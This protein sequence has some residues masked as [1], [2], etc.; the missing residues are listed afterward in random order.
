MRPR[1]L[2][3]EN[4]NETIAV[5]F[6]FQRLMMHPDGPGLLLQYNPSTG[7]NTISIL[8]SLL[9]RHL[10][11]PS[12][13]LPADTM[14]GIL[15]MMSIACKMPGL[16][17]LTLK[18]EKWSRII[19][20]SMQHQDPLVRQWSLLTFGTAWTCGNNRDVNAVDEALTL[21]EKCYI[22]D[23]EQVRMAAVYAI[24][25]C[26]H[27]HAYSR[28][29]SEIQKLVQ[30]SSARLFSNAFRDAAINVRRASLACIA[31]LFESRPSWLF[32]APLCYIGIKGKNADHTALREECEVFLQAC[33]HCCDLCNHPD[34]ARERYPLLDAACTAL[35][36]LCSDPDN[37]L[38]DCA[39]QVLTRAI[40][41]ATH[42]T[43]VGH[44]PALKDCLTSLS[45]CVGAGSMSEVD[46][47]VKGMY[48]Y[49][50]NRS[51]EDMGAPAS[52]YPLLLGAVREVIHDLPPAPSNKACSDERVFGFHD[53][54]STIK[55]WRARAEGYFHTP[56][57]IVS[58]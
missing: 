25:N 53:L 42:S 18:D 20:T 58:Q 43:I 21:V 28:A 14:A 2:H 49:A 17:P 32:L 8:T 41:E 6:I 1:L 11:D 35:V 19:V 7:V 3:W 24:W 45:S 23:S 40:I 44:L 13:P 12:N 37:R 29:S 9:N 30:R 57:L 4:E 16:S 10:L 15:Y 55:D 5:V 50:P 26:H 52:Q 46:A 56:R 36:G 47:Y 38:Q 34:I 51:E 22:D 39:R 54:A 31:Q 33:I 48:G 27:T